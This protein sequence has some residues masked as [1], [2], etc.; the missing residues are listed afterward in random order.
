MLKFTSNYDKLENRNNQSFRNSTRRN[1]RG[2]NVDDIEFLSN[3][4][5]ST[6]SEINSN[7]PKTLYYYFEESFS[8]DSLRYN[9]RFVTNYDEST[10]S[11]QLNNYVVKIQKL[12]AITSDVMEANSELASYKT[13]VLDR[14]E[15]AKTLNNEFQSLSFEPN[16]YQIQALQNY[17]SDLKLA[18]KNLIAV[19]GTINDQINNISTNNPTI[20][21]SIDIMNS[22]Y[23]KLLNQLDIR[24]TYHKNAIATLEQLSYILEDAMFNQNASNDTNNESMENSSNLEDLN[25]GTQ[26]ENDTTL[27]DSNNTSN[28]EEVTDLEDSNNSNNEAIENSE[29]TNNSLLDS[30]TD[31]SLK[32]IDT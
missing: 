14:I 29:K 10:T 1:E 26:V 28:N 4:T 11:D 3:E 17:L 18:N 31:S 22:N 21:S 20:T 9:P 23:L 16:I 6:N 13:A 32:N 7:Q 2:L 27:P 30:Y 24:I 8:P 12:Y 19:N 15:S 5:D 25:N